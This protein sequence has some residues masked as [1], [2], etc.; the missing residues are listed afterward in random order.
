MIQRRSRYLIF[1]KIYY[2]KF[3]YDS[4]KTNVNSSRWHFARI[5]LKKHILIITNEFNLNRNSIYKEVR[6]RRSLN[7]FVLP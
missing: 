5:R 4:I 3:F 1:R 7:L 2:S 6:W